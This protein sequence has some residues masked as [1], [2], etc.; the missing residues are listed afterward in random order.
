MTNTLA[1]NVEDI[2]TTVKTFIVLV[3]GIKVTKPFSLNPWDILLSYSVF[4][5]NFASKT[6]VYPIGALY[7]ATL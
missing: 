5:L 1:Y 4:G 2:I 3:H 7:D 6:R